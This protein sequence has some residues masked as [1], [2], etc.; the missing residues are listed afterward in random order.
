MLRY[1]G[2]YTTAAYGSSAFW[3]DEL[4]DRRSQ[5]SKNEDSEHAPSCW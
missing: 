1:K 2:S 4:L 5:R 3:L